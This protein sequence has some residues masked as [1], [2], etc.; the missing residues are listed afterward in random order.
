M[1]RLTNLE[2][3]TL[4]TLSVPKRCLLEQ[5]FQSSLFTDEIEREAAITRFKIP[6]T[7][8]DLMLIETEND[9]DFLIQLENDFLITANTATY[10]NVGF[11]YLQPTSRNRILSPSDFIEYVNRGLARAFNNSMG[12]FTTFYKNH[13]NTNSSY[14]TGVNTSRNMSIASAGTTQCSH[15]KLILNN[16]TVV[17]QSANEV[18]LV[19]IDLKSPSGLSCRVASCVLLEAGKIYIFENGGINSY[20]SAKQDNN[21]LEA[22]YSMTPMESFLKF[23]DEPINGNWQLLIYTP[24]NGSIDITIN[25]QLEVA[26]PPHNSNFRFSNQPPV[27]DFDDK[28]FISWSLPERFLYNDNRIKL[29]NKLKTVLNYYKVTED[30]GYVKFP[31]LTFSSALDQ[32]I[33]LKQEAN[34]LYNIVQPER[35]QISLFGMNIDRDFNNDLNPSS[36]ITS[37]LLPAD[38]VI[39]FTEITYNTDASIKPYRRYKLHNLNNLNR[40]NISVE[41]VYKDGKRRELFMESNATFNLMLSI[42]E[43]K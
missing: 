26:S 28:G 4:N 15:V 19:N 23:K 13:T 35:L 22:T 2:L 36:A 6:I 21:T 14:K 39:N 24:A 43:I 20:S 9:P 37:F 32:I 7:L 27:V 40:F 25:S 17:T 12:L 42:F 30:D 16:F 29:G 33:T 18:N 8:M 11:T 1:S 38:E 31:L 5:E 34:R 10:T 3:S 41:I